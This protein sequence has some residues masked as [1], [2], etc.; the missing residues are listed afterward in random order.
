MDDNDHIFL[1]I[2]STEIKSKTVIRKLI[3]II[4]KKKSTRLKYV[5]L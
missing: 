2:N 3:I 5:L 4:I 1:K